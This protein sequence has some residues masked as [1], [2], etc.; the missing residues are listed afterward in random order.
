MTMALEEER[1]ELKS[2]IP[3]MERYL[4]H[5]TDKK[6]SLQRYI[7]KVKRVTHLTE[8]TPKLVQNRKSMLVESAGTYYNK[9]EEKGGCYYGESV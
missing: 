8:L 2:V 3:E 9:G 1:Q 4:E 5:E 6:Y 7:D